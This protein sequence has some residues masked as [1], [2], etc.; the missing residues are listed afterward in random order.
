MVFFCYSKDLD[1]IDE[2]GK[3][4]REICNK[5][6]VFTELVCSALTEYAMSNH[7]KERIGR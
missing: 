7:E 6:E 3:R 2:L 4:F 1:L 5:E